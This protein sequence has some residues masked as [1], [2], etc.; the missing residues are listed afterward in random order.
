MFNPLVAIHCTTSRLGVLFQC[1]RC[2]SAARYGNGSLVRAWRVALSETMI[3]PKTR[4]LKAHVRDVAATCGDGKVLSWCLQLL[5]RQV[6][7]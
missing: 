4:F 6:G 2:T 1:Q 7:K 5:V 3:L